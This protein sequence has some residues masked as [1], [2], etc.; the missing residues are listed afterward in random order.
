[1]P[2]NEIHENDVGTEL[3]ITLVDDSTPVDVSGASSIIFVFKKPSGTMVEKTGSLYSDGTDGKVK[4]ITESGFLDEDGE[5]KYQVEL[6]IGSST[7]SS[8]IGCL[9]IHPNL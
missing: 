1:M 8:D 7:W 5:W 3:R 9:T 2:A 6:S 4:Y